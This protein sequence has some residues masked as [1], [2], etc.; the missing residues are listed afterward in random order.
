MNTKQLTQ[1]I[2]TRQERLEKVTYDLGRQY[3]SLGDMIDAAVDNRESDEWIL[4]ELE[5]ETFRQNI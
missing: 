2:I 1:S 4:K 5:K 3:I